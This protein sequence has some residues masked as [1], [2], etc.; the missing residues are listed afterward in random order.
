MSRATVRGQGRDPGAAVLLDLSIYGCR[1][2]MDSQHGEGDRVWLRL[3][4]GW[5]IGATVVWVEDGRMGCRFDDPL[6]GSVMRELMR[7]VS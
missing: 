6:P 7:P 3:D 2:A 4:G 5:P 1:I